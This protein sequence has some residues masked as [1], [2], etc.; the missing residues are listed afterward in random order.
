MSAVDYIPG[1]GVRLSVSMSKPHQLVL[2][3]RFEHE[4]LMELNIAVAVLVV[5]IEGN[6]VVE[7][8]VVLVGVVAAVVEHEQSKKNI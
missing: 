4:L 7:V 5:R 3:F 2:H 8:F 6:G 1:Q